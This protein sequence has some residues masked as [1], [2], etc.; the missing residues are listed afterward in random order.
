MVRR[1][2]PPSLRRPS[3]EE[4]A[5]THARLAFLFP[6][7]VSAEPPVTGGWV[8]DVSGP[9][10]P[11]VDPGTVT[12]PVP[13]L[14]DWAPGVLERVGLRPGGAV[15]LIAVAAV[16]VVVAG[17]FALRARPHPVTVQAPTTVPAS[18]AASP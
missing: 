2:I 17:A 10:P 6:G 15:G 18:A 11:A 1:L 16:A 14:P 9:R 8:P 13:A 3:P 7:H 4:V 12:A 5:A